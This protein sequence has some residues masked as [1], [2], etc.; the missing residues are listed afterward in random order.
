M[1]LTLFTLTITL[2]ATATIKALR[3]HKKL[4]LQK[5]RIRK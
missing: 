5:L 4:A 3:K 2:A 1:G